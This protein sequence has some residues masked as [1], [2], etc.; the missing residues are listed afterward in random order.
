MIKTNSIGSSGTYNLWFPL[1]FPKNLVQY[2][3]DS[4]IQ[5]VNGQIIRMLRWKQKQIDDFFCDKFKK[6]ASIQ[7]WNPKYIELLIPTAITNNKIAISLSD[8]ELN[9]SAMKA[10]IGPQ[11]PKNNHGLIGKLHM[12]SYVIFHRHTQTHQHQFIIYSR[13]SLP[14]TKKNAYQLY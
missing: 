11:W 7:T 5:L 12:R 4:S 9:A 14:Q 8:S 1:E 3:C 6:M 13:S 2:R 10:H